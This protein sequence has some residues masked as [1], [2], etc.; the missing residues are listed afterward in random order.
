MIN[1][2]LKRPLFVFKMY[3]FTI[4]CTEFL[5]QHVISGYELVDINWYRLKSDF[6][7]RFFRSN[8]SKLF[9]SHVFNFRTVNVICIETYA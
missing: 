8:E 7:L 9:L 5:K 2:A 3:F 1:L 6:Y 4:N